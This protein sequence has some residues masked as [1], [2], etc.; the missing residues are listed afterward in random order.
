[1]KCTQDVI[2]RSAVVRLIPVVLITRKYFI[3]N[4]NTLIQLF[5]FCAWNNILWLDG[6]LLVKAIHCHYFLYVFRN[7][8]IVVFLLLPL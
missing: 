4:L 7:R 3:C 5:I 8:Q 6:Q 1:M 2:L